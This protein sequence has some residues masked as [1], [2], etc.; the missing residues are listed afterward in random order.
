MPERA[1]LL[2]GARIVLRVQPP[3][4]TDVEALEEGTIVIG[5]M[6]PANNLE[7]IKRMRD[8]K[9]TAFALELVPRISRA[10]SMDALNSQATAGMSR[11]SLVL[12]TARNSCRC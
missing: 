3:T 6:N 8:R 10:Q 12:R 5:F 1:M 2:D 9:I 4:A 11:L 7:A